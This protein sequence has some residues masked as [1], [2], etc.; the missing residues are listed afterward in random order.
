MEV[1]IVFLSSHIRYF[2]SGAGVSS[3]KYEVL[4]FYEEKSDKRKNR[5]SADNVK[6]IQKDSYKVG[7]Q[8]G[9]QWQQL[10]LFRSGSDVCGWSFI[11]AR[12]SL[13]SIH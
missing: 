9:Q 10:S 8:R 11:F 7:S 6:L 5:Q 3:M 1:I 2:E 4:T 13:T 12:P